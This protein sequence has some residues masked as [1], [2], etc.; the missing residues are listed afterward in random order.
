MFILRIIHIFSLFAIL[1]H[2]QSKCF[3][4]SVEDTLYHSRINSRIDGTVMRISPSQHYENISMYTKVMEQP[5]IQPGCHVVI[6]PGCEVLDEQG[7]PE[8]K[9]K[10]DVHGHVESIGE[11]NGMMIAIIGIEAPGR[12]VMRVQHAH[13]PELL[14]VSVQD[15]HLE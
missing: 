4:L 11:L 5:E 12:P 7:Q 2:C 9:L 8:K 13:W 3:L 10:V 15:R 14:V 6:Q 1:N